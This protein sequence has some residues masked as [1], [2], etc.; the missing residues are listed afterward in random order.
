MIVR[1]GL[2]L[3][4]YLHAVLILA[5]PVPL[6]L[7]LAELVKPEEMGIFYLKCLLVAIPVIA[8]ERAAK[9]AKGPVVYL[10]LCAVVLAGV[11]CV[12]GLLPWALDQRKQLQAA[13]LC[14]C[15]GM[16]AETFLIAVK[17]FQDRLREARCQ[18]GDDPFAAKEKSFWDN[19]TPA[20]V[21][22]FVAVYLFGI[23]FD[24]KEL[25]DMAFYSAIV[26]LFLSLFYV[27]FSTTKT[28]LK[29]N[30]RTKGIPRK[31]LYGISSMMLLRFLLLLFAGVIPAVLMAGQRQYTDVRSWFDDVEVVP[32][33]Y[34]S[35]SEFKG[36]AAGG[37]DML[38]LM[39]DNEPVPEP[40][41]FVNTVFWFIGAVCLLA[42][43]YGIFQMIRQVLL[44]F[45]NSFDE[46]GDV[47]EQ[48]EDEDSAF[49][50]ELMN[51][52]RLRGMQSEAE[53]IRRRYRRTIRKHR[54][55]IPKPYEA[56][57]EIEEGAGLKEDEQMKQLHIKYEAVRYGK[58]ICE[59]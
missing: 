36:A 44:D 43:F 51:L 23:F 59:K 17:H 55:D 12:T 2:K 53:K 52:K 25:C 3:I 18:K 19:P 45:R 37:A 58:T 56:P 15:V 38:A 32:Y 8:I 13:D 14:Y 50:E 28:Y 46:N 42:F 22:Y 6:L 5:L 47:I 4:T 21:W 40:S 35:D 48:I 29:Q 30:Q 9:Y 24:A 27:H 57:A 41:V 39:S 54:K 49:Q 31:R 26:Y 20:L 7:A 33:E 11:G 10:L 16:L 1:R 34:Q